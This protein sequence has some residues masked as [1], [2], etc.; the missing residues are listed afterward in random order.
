MN[1]S[2]FALL[3]LLLTVACAADGDGQV[4]G[5]RGGAL[6]S[7]DGLVSLEVPEGS[8]REEIEVQSR[9]P[10]ALPEGAVGPA[11]TFG[12][13]G[14][15]LARGGMVR[16]QLEADEMELAGLH[17]VAWRDGTWAE[18]PEQE[19]DLD[20]HTISGFATYLSTFAVVAE[21]QDDDDDDH[22]HGG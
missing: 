7:A 12:P 16:I 6:E 9:A 21:E 15:G 4:L 14:T 8:V 2:R 11:W 20:A 22:G 10:E 17:L 19:L 3:P 5:P 18:L 13:V 1:A